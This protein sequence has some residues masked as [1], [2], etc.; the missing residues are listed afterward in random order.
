M[1]MA[2]PLGSVLLAA[3]AVIALRDGMVWPRWLAGLGAVAA[4][5]YLLRVGTLFTA[6]GAFAAD[7]LLGFWLPVLAIAAWVSVASVV[8]ALGL[9]RQSP[10]I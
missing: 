2:A 3:F 1:G 5:A 9:R 4:L 8:L 7:G 10:S 6:E